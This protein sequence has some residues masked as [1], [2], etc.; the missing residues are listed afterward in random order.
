MMKYIPWVVTLAVL[1]GVLAVSGIPLGLA[2]ASAFPGSSA[3]APARFQAAT[4][5]PAA[6]MPPVAATAEPGDIGVTGTGRVSVEPDTAFITV[7]AEATMATLSAATA[8]VA[9]RTTAVLDKVKSLGVDSKNIQTVNY[10]IYPQT[11]SP[12]QG[13]TPQITGY[14]VTNLLRIK[15]AKDDVAKVLDAAVTAGANSVSNIQFTINDSTKA[16]SD[17][18]T[19]AVKA[20][21]VKARQIADA[22]GVKL[23]DIRSITENV[24]PRPIAV[25]RSVAAPAA[26]ADVAGPVEGGSLEISVTVE[27]HYDIVK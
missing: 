7:G 23:G 17:A 10:S 27:L 15:V 8:D 20:A 4:P 25:Q 3:N 18:R 24:S 11:N 2:D 6:A 9:K 1:A 16:E 13:E 5:T 26:A 12:R 22:A 21:M 19:L 14:H